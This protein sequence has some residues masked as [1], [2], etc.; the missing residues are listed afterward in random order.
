MEKAK[1]LQRI[2][3]LDTIADNQGLD[4]DGWALRYHL[5]DQLT[6][7]LAAEEEYW[8]QRGR[9]QWILMGDANTKYFH[10]MA[11]GRRRK[12]AIV[13]LDSVEGPVSD[14]GE[15]QRIIYSFYL[16]LMGAE[17]PK[18]LPLAL[19]IWL[20]KNRVSKEENENLLRSFSMEELED[21]LKDTKYDTA[22]GP[23]GIPV[24]FYK[25]F[26]PMIKVSVL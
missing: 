23:D 15:I 1:L 8:R 16:E 2:Q 26:W 22:P 7:I 14:K 20:P 25:R 10:A 4:E 3:E 21:V 12:C 6:A 17:E 18:L 13:P 5:E 24:L 19:D 11:N 9:Q